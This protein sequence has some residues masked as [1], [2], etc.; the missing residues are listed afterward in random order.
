MFGF[1]N[2]KAGKMIGVP[3]SEAKRLVDQANEMNPSFAAFRDGVWQEFI[4]NDGVG[5]TLYGKRLVYPDICLKPGRK[6]NERIA[7]AK[8]QAFNAKIQGTAADILKILSFPA[9]TIAW[10]YEYAHI[11][12]VHDELLFMGMDEVY[13]R[14]L[15]TALNSVFS[16]S[17]L[18]GVPVE[19]AAKIGS[20][21]FDVH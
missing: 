8:R 10:R 9:V 15:C 21:W 4:D 5:H 11:A 16:M 1:G 3:E 19:G 6:N 20:S 13:G 12:P 17:L 14:E 2:K 7:R 18:P